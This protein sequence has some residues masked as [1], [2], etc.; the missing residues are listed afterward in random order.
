MFI[1]IKTNVNSYWYSVTKNQWIYSIESSITNPETIIKVYTLDIP[2]IMKR[3]LSISDLNGIGES[4]FFP[5]YIQKEL[6]W[7]LNNNIG[8]LIKCIPEIISMFGLNNII[9]QNELFNF[10][11]PWNNREFLK[12]KD[13]IIGY[14]Y[15]GEHNEIKKEFKKYKHLEIPS[16]VCNL[17]IYLENNKD[18]VNYTTYEHNGWF[19]GSGAI[20]SSNKTVVQLRLKQAGM[21][22]SVNGANYI[23]ALRC[24]VES[25]N[26][27]KIEKIVVDYFNN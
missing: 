13:K 3:R 10:E 19:V 22:W 12:F 16:T 20:E 25:D 15:S 4:S 9:K 1:Y 7:L 26:W 18:K 5:K 17:P 23:I 27:D 2:K 11:L 24:M 14:C 8:E 21:R 6:K